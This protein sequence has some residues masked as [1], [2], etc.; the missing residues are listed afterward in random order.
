MKDESASE[1]SEPKDEPV[2]TSDSESEQSEGEP[3]REVKSAPAAA[4]DRRPGQ[5]NAELIDRVVTGGVGRVAR[6]V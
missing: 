3:K 6:L 5:D 1:E 2:G 4:P